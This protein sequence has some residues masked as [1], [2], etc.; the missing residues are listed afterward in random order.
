MTDP[1]GGFVR[2]RLRL[3]TTKP[4]SQNSTRCGRFVFHFFRIAF[5]RSHWSSRKNLIHEG[6][7][8]LAKEAAA[9][10]QIGKG[11]GGSKKEKLPKKTISQKKRKIGKKEEDGKIPSLFGFLGELS[12]LVDVNFRCFLKSLSVKFAVFIKEVVGHGSSQFCSLL[13]PIVHCRLH[14]LSVLKETKEGKMRWKWG[15]KKM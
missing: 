2:A 3:Q 12:D 5:R 6:K 4:H 15:Q 13:R 14:P 10:E 1:G 11:K 8:K 7:H 9:Q